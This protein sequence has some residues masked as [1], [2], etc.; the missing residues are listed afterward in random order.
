M[1]DKNLY[2]QDFIKTYLK[3]LMSS[4]NIIS[5]LVNDLLDLAQVNKG[6]FQL[7]F[8]EFELE[9]FLIE[10]STQMSF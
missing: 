5:G 4:A 10:I 3:P 6:K 2:D 1:I 8:C 7:N 9:N